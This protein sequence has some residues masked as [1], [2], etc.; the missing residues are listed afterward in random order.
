MVIGAVV[1]IRLG[2]GED[3]M[4]Q[5]KE[6]AIAAV[7][8][9]HEKK[10]ENEYD[11]TELLSIEVIDGTD[12]AGIAAGYFNWPQGYGRSNQYT[13]SRWYGHIEGIPFE[14]ISGRVSVE[15]KTWDE[16]IGALDSKKKENEI[17][18]LKKEIEDKIST[19]AKNGVAASVTYEKEDKHD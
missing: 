15:G 1:V 2:Q 9:V 19:L 12:G 6:E 8:N 3:E 18:T 5:S 14:H 7:P 16:L 17:Q 10:K 11:D 13:Y 4:V